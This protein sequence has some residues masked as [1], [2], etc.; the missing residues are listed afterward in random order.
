M[1]IFGS[2]ISNF[3]DDG[4]AMRFF[5]LL[6]EQPPGCDSVLFQGSIALSQ[7]ARPPQQ[8]FDQ[9]GKQRPGCPKAGFGS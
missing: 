7:A 4:K 5:V 3:R 9:T 6:Q 1:K 8:L 2:R